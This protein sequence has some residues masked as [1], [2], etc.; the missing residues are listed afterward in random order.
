VN[1]GVLLFFTVIL[2][3]LM[4]SH[5]GD[6]GIQARRH[7][8]RRDPIL[9]EVIR[10]VGPLTLQHNPDGFAVLVHSIISQQIS[11]KAAAAI[12]TRLGGLLEPRGIT[13]AGLRK[14][15]D[16]S[17][18]V[19]GLSAAKIRSLRHLADKVYWGEVGLYNLDRLSDEEV[20]DLLIPLH[21]IGP[22]TAQMFLIFSLGRPDVL[23]VAD[24][25]L[26]AGVQRQYKLRKL[27]DRDRLT[28]LAEAWRPYRSI[29]TWYIWRSLGAVPQSG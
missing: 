15:S 12:R 4:N 10:L 23:P 9:R 11:T 20:I 24:F 8:S 6:I 1:N 13:V 2:W 29:A 26:R 3:K 17:L 25:G 28:E 21:G 19:A 5:F 18:R 14:A 27:P 7:L 22:W 16:E